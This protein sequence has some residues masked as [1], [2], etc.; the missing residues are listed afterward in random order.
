MIDYI[1]GRGVSRALGDKEEVKLAYSKRSGR[2]KLARVGGSLFATV[3]PNGSMALTIH[4][5][6]ILMRRKKEFMKNC[7]VVDDDAAEFVVGGKS[8]FCKFVR[9]AGGNIYPKSETVVLDSRGRILGVGMAVVAGK[10]MAQFPSGVAVKIRAG[11]RDHP[12]P[13]SPN[14]K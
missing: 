4:G 11:V 1:F 10:F 3:K 14:K 2:V 7:I 6:T 5:A 9:K 13:G 8:V 12:G